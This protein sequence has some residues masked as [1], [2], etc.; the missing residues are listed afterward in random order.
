MKYKTLLSIAWI[1]TMS[2]NSQAQQNR[3]TSDLIYLSGF[4]VIP[5]LVDYDIV[6]VRFPITTDEQGPGESAG[7]VAIPAGETVYTMQSGADLV[8]LK[9]DGTEIV[10][11]DCDVTCSVMDP[12]ISYDAKTVYY[13]INQ[14]IA[15][16][17]YGPF[18]DNY[19]SWIYK[20]HLMDH[21]DFNNYT[22]IR[23]TFDDGFDSIN[24]QANRDNNGNIKDGH[25]QSSWRAIRDFAPVPLAD[26][27]L[28]F[29]SNRSA[30]TAFHPGTNAGW[31][32]TVFN[33]AGCWHKNKDICFSL[34]DDITFHYSP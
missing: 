13:S 10:L 11:E 5:L 16:D 28:L 34:C 33:L 31:Q 1:L 32:N 14:R 24:Y 20:I 18:S 7:R 9:Q 30:L 27:R 15:G 12:F 4:E 19:R 23:L 22:P 6:Y 17:P 25:D 21:P 3:G 2:F 29:T 8:L 26:G